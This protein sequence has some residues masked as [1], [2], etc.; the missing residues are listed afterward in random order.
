MKQLQEILTFLLHVD[1]YLHMSVPV[2]CCGAGRAFKCNPGAPRFIC[3][4]TW[5]LSSRCH[6]PIQSSAID[7]CPLPGS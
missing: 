2:A 7:S 4:R 1:M 6:R 5:A 3:P